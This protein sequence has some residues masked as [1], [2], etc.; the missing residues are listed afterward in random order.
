MDLVESNG[1]RKADEMEENDDAPDQESNKV[2][3]IDDD[4]ASFQVEVDPDVF[5]MVRSFKGKT[6]IDLRRYYKVGVLC[7]VSSLLH[8]TSCSL[9][10]H[11]Y[12]SCFLRV[13]CQ[14]SG[15]L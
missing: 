3:R 7:P 4:S 9:H 14:G 6:L 1:K 2:P 15:L 11:C 13:S 5:L 10:H 8:Q 12:R